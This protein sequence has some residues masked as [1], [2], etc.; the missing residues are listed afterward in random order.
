VKLTDVLSENFDDRPE[1]TNGRSTSEAAIDKLFG[2]M[3]ALGPTG[4]K[5]IA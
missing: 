2:P 4:A 1:G 3:A 5:R